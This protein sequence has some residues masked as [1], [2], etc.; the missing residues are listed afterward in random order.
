MVVTPDYAESDKYLLF[1]N[2]SDGTQLLLVAKNRY[3]A[4]HALV[5]DSRNPADCLMIVSSGLVEMCLPVKEG[6]RV[7]SIL[8]RGYE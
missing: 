4:S 2:L 8:R 7:L 1:A 3:F 5:A 6:G